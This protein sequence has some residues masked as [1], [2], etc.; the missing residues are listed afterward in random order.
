MVKN[1][2]KRGF[3]DIIKDTLSFISQVI[4]ANILP[5]IAEGTE[6]V[7]NNIEDKV[8]RIETRIMRKMSS[9]LI[10][11]LGT[12]FLIFALF[13]F[14]TENIGLSKAAG[15]FSI[16]ITIFVIGLLLKIRGSDR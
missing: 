5:S 7:I 8:L 4:T 13:F 9:Y 3:V 15:F 16:G 2:R 10:I 6:I 12:L 1:E 14:L 11:G